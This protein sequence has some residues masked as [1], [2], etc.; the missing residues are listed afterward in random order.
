MPKLNY[1]RSTNQSSSPLIQTTLPNYGSRDESLQVKGTLLEFTKDMDQIFPP[2]PNTDPGAEQ[3]TADLSGPM[4]QLSTRCKGR[5]DGVT[6][7]QKLIDSF[8]LDLYSNLFSEEKPDGISSATPHE[9]TAVQRGTRE[10]LE[11]AQV[12][13]CVEI[14]HTEEDS[15]D[16]HHS[17]CTGDQSIKLITYLVS[18][19]KL[20][21]SGVNLGSRF[22]LSDLFF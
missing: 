18:L 15:L 9:E 16:E 13:H 4:Q 2:T 12:K 11:D 17:H 10:I 1:C 6:T 21:R 7:K 22:N 8:G 5:K 14:H 20:G 3:T 19:G